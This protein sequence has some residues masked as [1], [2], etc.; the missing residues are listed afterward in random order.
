MIRLCHLGSGSSG[1]CL[2]LE[3]GDGALVLDAGFSARE[4]M[5]RMRAA[6]LDPR[7]A[8]GIVV[9]HEHGDHARGAGV[10][11]RA[12]KIPVHINRPSY[13]AARDMLGAVEHVVFFETGDSFT[14]AGFTVHSFPVAHDSADP[15]AFVF[16]H[17]GVHVAAVT[18]TGVVTTLIRERLRGADYLV[19]EANHD[20]AMLQAGPY[21]WPLKQR[22]ASR[23]GHLSNEACGELVVE[24]AHPNLRGVTFAHLSETNNN[25]DLVRLVARDALARTQTPFQIARQ[26]APVPAVVIE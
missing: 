4:I 15:C 22:I 17:E 1:N 2:W 20:P 12:L 10:L 26:D 19:V 13:A 24:V 5:R 23:S 11:A 8:R 14:L 18:D 3:N 25:P 7:R 16:G 21:P 6:G 9:S